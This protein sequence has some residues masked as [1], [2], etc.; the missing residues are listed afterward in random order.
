VLPRRPNDLKL[1]VLP[2]C[3]KSKTLKDDPNLT[4]E[5]SAIE[6]PA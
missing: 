2:M 3:K 6:D 1:I 5:K 4:V